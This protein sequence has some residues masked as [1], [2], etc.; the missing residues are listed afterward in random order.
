LTTRR[1][2]QP[3]LRDAARGTVVPVVLPQE[4]PVSSARPH[5]WEMV[6]HPVKTLRFVNDLRQDRRISLMRKLLYLGPMLLLLLAVLLPEGIIAAV[7]A[8]V[9]PLVG[10]A[11]NLPTD[12]VMYWAFLGIASYALLGIFPRMIVAEHHAQVFHPR[13]IARQ[14]LSRSVLS[15]P[16]V[17]S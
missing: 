12:A 14:R 13:R 8:T 3:N 10:P 17:V 16:S 9:L 4:S 6:L 1:T 5:P 2:D 15:G 7:V 11:I